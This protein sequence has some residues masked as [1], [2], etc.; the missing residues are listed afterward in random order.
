M[1]LLGVKQTEQTTEGVVTRQAVL[2]LEKA[3]QERLLRRG[4]PRHVGRASPA[5]QDGAQRD[6]QQFVQVMQPGIAGSG[7]LQFF[8][9]GDK[10][11]QRGLQDWNTGGGRI[12]R[13][14]IGQ[15][16]IRMSRKF[17]M[18]LN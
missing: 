1:K 7:V 2:E 17:Q 5:A 15:A 18:R 14:R 6:E 9:A 13:V 12:H 8:K 16:A 3:A 4:E 11:V 10:L